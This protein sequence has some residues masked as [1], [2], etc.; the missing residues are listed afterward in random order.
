[1]SIALESIEIDGRAELDG[2]PF[3]ATARTLSFEAQMLCLF[4][5]TS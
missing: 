4:L 3:S 5:A 2:L 1:M